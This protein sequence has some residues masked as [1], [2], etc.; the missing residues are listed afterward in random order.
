MPNG[1]W[2]LLKSF[3]LASTRLVKAN[4]MAAYLCLVHAIILHMWLKYL[5]T[6]SE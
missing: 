5:R 6:A 4:R 3:Y 1:L 2:S